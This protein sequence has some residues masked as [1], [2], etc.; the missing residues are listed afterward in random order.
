MVWDH[1]KN[2]QAFVNFPSG[3]ASKKLDHTPVHVDLA[4]K[5]NLRFLGV[6]QYGAQPIVAV[7]Q[8]QYRGAS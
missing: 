8:L 4:R 5:E 6:Y 7:I 1:I 2:N 3:R